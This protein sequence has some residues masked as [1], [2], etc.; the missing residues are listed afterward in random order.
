[1]H[2]L[3]TELEG[4]GTS[5]GRRTSGEMWLIPAGRR[6]ASRA[7]GGIITYAELYIAPDTLAELVGERAKIEEIAPRLAHRD[8]FLYRSVQRL[9]G[10]IGQADDLSEMLGQTLSRASCLHLLREYRAGSGSQPAGRN[11][12]IPTPRAA[13]SLQEYVQAH[14]AERIT[15]DALSAL[16]GLSTHNLLIAF[17][18]AFGTTP[19]Q[20]VIAQRLRHV[21][22]L[23]ANTAADITTIALATGFASHSHLAATLKKQTGLTPRDFRARWR[24]YDPSQVC[25]SS[26]PSV[27]LPPIWRAS[28]ELW[29]LIAPILAEH[30]PP[31]RRPQRIGR[32]RAGSQFTPGRAHSGTVPQMRERADRWAATQR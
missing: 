16:A 23:L 18:Q 10:L 30:D 29:A 17:G 15:L 32:Q 22:W 13:Q 14:L 9:A 31:K 5:R 26:R 2:E 7:R 1:M 8:E 19:A 24:E 12:P 27:P 21:R 3:E 11:G 25:P 6:Y 4:G 20:Y 28:D